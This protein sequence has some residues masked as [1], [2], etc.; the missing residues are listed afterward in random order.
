MYEG[1]EMLPAGRTICPRII[2]GAAGAV[3]VAVAVA[4]ASAVSH[5]GGESESGGSLR[6]KEGAN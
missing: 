3:A 4:T 6:T 5:E 1:E 2:R